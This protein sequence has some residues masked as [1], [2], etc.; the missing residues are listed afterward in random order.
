MTILYVIV[1]AHSVKAT[2]VIDDFLRG[3]G[4]ILPSRFAA[5]SYREG[6][7]RCTTVM[8]FVTSP[9]KS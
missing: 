6:C 7:H 4:V 2:G 5:T 3:W 9:T 1:Y 8:L